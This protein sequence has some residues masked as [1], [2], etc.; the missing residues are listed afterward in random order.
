MTEETKPTATDE[1]FRSFEDA[2]SFIR[3]RRFRCNCGKTYWDNYNT[4]N[5]WN[6]GEIEALEK[7][8]NAQA[9]LHA[10]TVVSFEGTEYAD[11]C[12]CWRPRAA[13]LINWLE[14]HRTE[15]ISFL[16]MEKKRLIAEAQ[17]LAALE[18]K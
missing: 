12:D 15:I 10:I 4:G 13:R 7:D 18:D 14:A 16:G 1:Q 11:A 8:E 5:D 2:F 17:N 6:E 9:C 3:T